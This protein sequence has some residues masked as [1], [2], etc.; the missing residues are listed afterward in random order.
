MLHNKNVYICEKMKLITEGNLCLRR[1]MCFGQK[2]GYLNKM[3]DNSAI[4]NLF[5]M[6]F[7]TLKDNVMVNLNIKFELSTFNR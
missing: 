3:A 5:G 4:L 6:K 1:E 2:R 7:V